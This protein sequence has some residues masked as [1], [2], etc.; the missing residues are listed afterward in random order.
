[1]AAYEGRFRLGMFVVALAAHP[2]CVVLPHSVAATSV[3][4]PV[5]LFVG[6][7]L[8]HFDWIDPSSGKFQLNGKHIIL[9]VEMSFG[10][11]SVL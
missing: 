8:G 7:R 4:A 6:V 3:F 5:T 9:K 1:M 11:F 10:F 2:L